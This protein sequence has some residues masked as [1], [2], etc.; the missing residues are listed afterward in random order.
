MPVTIEARSLDGVARPVTVRHVHR[1][2]AD[3]WLGEFS[4]TRREILVF[5]VS[6]QPVRTDAP[7]T[8][9]FRRE[10]FLE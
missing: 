2:E 3:S 5:K 10:L 4:S 9:E 8:A 6:A 1:G 7:I